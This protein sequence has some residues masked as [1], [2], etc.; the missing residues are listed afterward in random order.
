MATVKE[1]L[2]A[3]GRGE[4]AI[5]R[6]D[7]E[8]LLSHCLGKPRTWLFTW[9]DAMVEATT[10]A[11]FRQL[12]QARRDGQPLAYLLGRQAFWSLSLAV[13]Q[14][15]LAPRADT[16]LLVYWALE[17]PLPA[18]ARVLELGTGSGAIALALAHE[19]PGWRIT[20][21]D[22]SAK[23]LQVARGNAGSLGLDQVNFLRSD[24]FEQVPLE[25][26]NLLLGNPPYVAV[27]DPH[28]RG[29]GVRHEPAAALVSG[30]D[31]LDALRLLAGGASRYLLRGGW[32]LLEHGH[33]QGEAVRGL[34]RA[35]GFDG[36]ET[37]CD[38]AG[39]ERVSGGISA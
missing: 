35:A 31:G 6:L 29:D 27:N 22:S 13:N 30:A 28:L 7:G 25:P 39:R 15:T 26:C 2:L 24:W 17:L 14:H 16:E 33:T 1:L 38:L 8:C 5:D 18:T 36:V 19:R 3:L 9:P 20:A 4:N 23:A 12:L 32:L 34:L 37:R 10:V 11:R 21:T